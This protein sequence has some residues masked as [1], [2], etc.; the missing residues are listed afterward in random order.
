MRNGL[1]HAIEAVRGVFGIFAILAEFKRE[2]IRERTIAGLEAARVRGAMGGRR[3]ALTKAQV[4]DYGLGGI[5]DLTPYLT[6]YGA[7]AG[8]IS[9]R[10][11]IRNSRIP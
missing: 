5:R 7:D 1:R 8:A 3:F 2:L 11:W 9:G 10:G 4:L 6:P